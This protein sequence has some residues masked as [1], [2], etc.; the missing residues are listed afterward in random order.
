MTIPADLYDEPGSRTR[1]AWLRTALVFVAVTLLVV[2]GL[3]LRGIP[4][5]VLA[6]AVALA[7]SFLALALRRAAQ[8]GPRESPGVGGG[9]VLSVLGIVVA[10][11]V[12]AIASLTTN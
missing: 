6:L 2:R 10:G 8:V 1:W 11:V 5:W 3:Y 4:T 7:G 9:T 12:L